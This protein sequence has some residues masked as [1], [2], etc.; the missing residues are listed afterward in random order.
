MSATATAVG[1]TPEP[2]H[3]ELRAPLF[4]AALGRLDDGHRHVV[5]DL[6][7]ARSGTISRFS[8]MRCR[9]DIANLPAVLESAG[10]E[11]NAAS[12]GKKLAAALPPPK[13]ERADLILC[14]NLL[15]Y[16][17]PDAIGTLMSA[18]ARRSQ[19][20][21]QVHALIEYSAKTMPAVPPSYTPAGSDRLVAVAP[22]EQ[23]IAAP[24]YAARDL[25]RVMSGFRHERTMLL[26][27]GMQEYLFA[28]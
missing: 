14:W 5:V 21:T 26:G 28:R 27:N 16:L 18:L 22:T 8:G 2:E 23:T 19:P 25:E 17:E 10:P 7:T 20:G 1:G 12:I 4:E 6:G 15:N 11:D 3:L 24:R 13:G 9:L